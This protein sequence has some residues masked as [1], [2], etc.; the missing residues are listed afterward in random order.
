[1]ATYDPSKRYTWSPEDKFEFSG[2]EFGLILNT[3]RAILNTE[4][5]A[6]ILLAK[7]CSDSIESVMKRSVENGIVKEQ[8]P[9]KIDNSGDLKEG[10]P[11][12]ELKKI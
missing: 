9:P 11:V 7:Q 2:Q 3:F 6:H 8:L 12:R 5:A 4:Q 10:P 1:M